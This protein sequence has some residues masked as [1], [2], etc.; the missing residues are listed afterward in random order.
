MTFQ[1][2]RVL[3]QVKRTTK[4]TSITKEDAK[5]VGDET[6]PVLGKAMHTCAVQEVLQKFSG[7]N[8]FWNC[9]EKAVTA[10]RLL[11]Q[12]CVALGSLM[13]V[14]SDGKSEYGYYYNPPYE[15]HAWVDLGAGMIF[16][17]ALPGVIEKGSNTSDS[18]GPFLVGRTP[19]ILNGP[20]QKWMRYKVH[21]YF[22][23]E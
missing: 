14:S 5:L 23:E 9:L 8:R 22:K 20:P 2:G 10:R 18:R 15:F 7:Y 11:K 21:Q 17:A 19:V 4:F 3:R 1:K 13:L 16:D 12:G 6:F